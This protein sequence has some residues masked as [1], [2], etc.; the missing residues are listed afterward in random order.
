MTIASSLFDAPTQSPLNEASDWLLAVLIG[1]VAVGLCVVAI[2]VIGLTMLTG[3]LPIRRGIVVVTGCFVLL[4]APIIASGLLT[5]TSPTFSE[6]SMPHSPPDRVLYERE[7]L[8]EATYN[9]YAGASLRR[10]SE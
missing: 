5:A 7:P 8:P 1:Q 10:Q 4:G 2:A 3:R 9:P 6:K